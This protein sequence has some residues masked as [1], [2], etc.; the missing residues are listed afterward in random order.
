[1]RCNVVRRETLHNNGQWE[2]EEEE[3]EMDSSSKWIMFYEGV[4]SKD[5]KHRVLMTESDDLQIWN[6]LGLALDTGANKEDDNNHAAW[7]SKGVGSPHVIR[8]DDGTFRMYYTGENDTGQTAI[9]VA[10]SMDMKIWNRERVMELSSLF[11]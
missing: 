10:R 6:E 8:L 9:G 11:S 5:G 4:S 7:D 3:N 2:N 1:M